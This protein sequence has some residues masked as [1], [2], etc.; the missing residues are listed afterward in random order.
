MQININTKIDTLLSHNPEALEAIVALNK[1]FVKLKNPVLR[2]ILAKRVNIA[3]AAKI[4]GVSVDAFFKALEPIGFQV[5]TVSNTKKFAMTQEQN[6]S[7]EAKKNAITLDVRPILDGG[8]DPFETIVAQLKKMNP[9]QV[10][11]IINTFKPVPLISVLGEKNYVIDAVQN[12]DK[13]FYTYFQ[14]PE[15]VVEEQP[16]QPQFSNFETVETMFEGKMVEID[17]RELEMPE[18]MITI[19]DQLGTLPEGH[20]LY[21][22]HK[23]V[24][25]FLLPELKK[26]DFIHVEKTIDEG[27][28]KMIIL[29][30]PSK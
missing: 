23:K 9:G 8:V 5:E 21:V 22:H 2:K 19:L 7:Q 28:V 12:E 15:K 16:A 25:Q 24:P 29:Q 13:L 17:V 27:D 11:L 6:I 3:T 14:V 10:L 26:R 30:N 18:P 4:G 1:N 20:C